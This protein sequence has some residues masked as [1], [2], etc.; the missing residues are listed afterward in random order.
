MNVL[1]IGAHPDDMEFGC[2]GTLALHKSRGDR[3]Y[4]IIVTNGELGG[5]SDMRKK[6]AENSSRLIA[7]K[8]FFANAP[9]GSVQDS[10]FLVDF[11]ERKIKENNID[12]IYTHTIHDRHQDHRHV[13]NASISAARNV[14]EVYSYETP[15][16]LYPFS[17][18]MFVNVSS[19]FK[20]KIQALNMHKSQTE[21]R[22]MEKEAVQGLAKYRGYQCG[23]HNLLCEAFE[24][25]R[26]MKD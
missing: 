10:H 22:Y 7:M 5:N 18:Q 21:K 17:P 20:T 3:I 19:T 16:V 8:L 25:N 14:D 24:V 11:V 23:K 6:E 12:I 2:F 4:G 26:I 9:D 15:S 1:A 13:A